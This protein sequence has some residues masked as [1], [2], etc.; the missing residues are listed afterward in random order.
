M[1]E[2]FL[3]R[4]VLTNLITI[5]V[6]VV[7]SWQFLRVRREAFP[8]ITFDIVIITTPYP[9]ASPEEVETQVTRRIEEQLREL[10]GIDRVE[11]FS[12]ENQS[13][14]VLRLEED[15][16]GREKD[17]IVN[18]IYQA[19]ARVEDL[20]EIADK[21]I[22][23]ELTSNRPLISVS[24]AG[25][26]QAERDRFADELKDMIEDIDGVARVDAE[27]DRDPEILIEADRR[28]LESYKVTM[29]ELAAAIR[30]RN[31]DRSA[32]GVPVGSLENWVR[33]R[34]S[35]FTAQEVSDI[36]VRGNDERRFIR[37]R[38]LA[39][40]SEGFEEQRIISRAGGQPA[41]ELRVSKHKLGDTIRLASAVKKLAAEQSARASQ[42][43][44]KLVISDDI[45][46]FIKRRLQ[47]MTNNLIQ[48]GFLILGAL[49]LFLDWRLAAVAAWGVPI[50]F[51][52]AMLVAVPM[53]FTINL[54][55]LLAFIIVLGMLDDDSVVVAENIY[56]HLE[57]GAPPE[58]AA[59]K[60]TREVL[61]PVLGS[62][63]VSCCA[64]LPFALMSGIMGKFLLMIPVVVCMCFL[65]SLFEAFFILPSHV[66]DL[67]PFGRPVGQSQESRWYLAAVDGYRRG[68]SWVLSH[69]LKFAGL[70]AVFVVLT[71]A[72]AALRVKFVLF[73]PGLIDQ[74]FIQLEMP[75]GTNLQATE[76]A[77]HYVEQE[78]LKLAPG[79]LEAVSGHVGLKGV[80]E[81][82]RIGTNYG[83]VRVFLTPEESR[84]R[85]TKAIIED[86]RAKIGLPPGAKRLVCEEL[87][88]GPPVGSAILVRA[89]GRD[90]Q[91][92]REIAE[93]IKAE[94]RAIDGVT[95]ILDSAEQ[96]K[97]Q[98][99]IKLEPREAA[100]SGL[101]VSRVAQDV[102]Y[103]V[104]GIDVSK[105]NRADEEVG[106][107]L[108]LLPE[109]RSSAGELLALD[110]LNASG[111][112][113][114]LN[115]VA[116]IEEAEGPPVL[117]RYNFKPALAV[118]ADVD[119]PKITSR[120]ANAR[121]QEKLKDIPKRYPGYELIFGGEEEETRKSLASLF[122]AFG[123][124]LLLDFVILA[125][126]FRS[127]AQ[128]IIILLTVPIGLLGVACALILHG[129]PASFMALLGVVAM[130]GVVVNNAIV[131][132]SFIND[133]CGK[134]MDARS[135]AV[136]AAAQR[137]RPIWASSITTLLGLFPTAYGFGGKE[138]FVAPMALS[139]AWGLTFAMPMTLFIIPLAYV[140]LD[141]V[142]TWLAA[143]VRRL[144]VW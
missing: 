64:F 114:P 101:D 122:R 3:S 2:Y 29:G 5:F 30:G 119:L 130:T 39:R 20:P 91:I 100:F 140:L 141:D 85:K 111:R 129:Q 133:N 79:E 46:F 32:G 96:G 87:K 139:L 26:S 106:I 42:K 107:R 48:G 81:H 28:K 89:R 11:S 108:R 121:I 65:A 116:R 15:L 1:I 124:A 49:F 97:R 126:L 94:L 13:L 8:D 38:D 33:V 123:T 41:I 52:A 9:G 103:A 50:S 76:R 138:P 23:R 18:E 75:P 71:A 102:F 58:R 104:D 105:I 78:V 63:L 110:V 131:L 86:L 35:V 128:P 45:S 6:V 142:R 117:Q 54:M 83:Q 95:D 53:G 16:S 14:I 62:V 55:S 109:Q 73:P 134:G 44:M 143:W 120:Q 40:V 88:P 132:V 115:K 19:A 10:S 61:L 17:R 43:G 60:G 69:R 92:N 84:P 80:E 99:L 7:G 93:A 51:A 21:P 22:V 98:W 127:Y 125:A 135:A 4:R 72:L 67:L 27:G 25:G 137:L 66:I 36:V 59:V 90:P 74:F 47:V 34:G 70:L 82:R 56:R 24:V 118:S 37:V 77:L 12:L 112:A 57:A 144:A 113:V 136:E 31:V 68:I